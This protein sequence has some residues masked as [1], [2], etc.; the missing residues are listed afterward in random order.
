M[1]EKIPSTKDPVLRS[2]PSRG[3]SPHRPY[4]GNPT[5]PQSWDTTE[6]GQIPEKFQTPNINPYILEFSN[7]NFSGAWSLKFG[8]DPRCQSC[9]IPSLPRRPGH[10]PFIADQAEEDVGWREIRHNLKSQS[11]RSIRQAFPFQDAQ[12]NQRFAAL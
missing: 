8:T 4:R 12:P 2:R 7:W 1:G 3:T 9:A 11:H 10:F 6:G 5:M